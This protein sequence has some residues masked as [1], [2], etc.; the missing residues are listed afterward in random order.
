MSHSIIF[1]VSYLGKDQPVEFERV[2]EHIKAK[3]PSRDQKTENGDQVRKYTHQTVE[4]Y[5][6]DCG[7]EFKN[8]LR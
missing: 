7:E 8:R 5:L 4:L 2:L 3:S 1:V 6:G